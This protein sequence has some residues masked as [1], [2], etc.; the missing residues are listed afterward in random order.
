MKSVTKMPTAAERVIG[1]VVP[2]PVPVTVTV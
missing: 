1:P 2:L